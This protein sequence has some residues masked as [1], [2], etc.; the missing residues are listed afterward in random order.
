MRQKFSL[1]TG[2][3]VFGFALLAGA[4]GL[5]R[6]GHTT[7]TPRHTSPDDKG[8]YA[9]LIDTNGGYAYFFGSY[10][11]KLDITGNLPVQIGPALSSGQY[12][13]G[14]ID[15]AAGYAYMP[16]AGTIYRYA[17]GAGTNAV[18]A[19]GSLI[20]PEGASPSMSIVVDDSDPNPANHY[21]YVLCSGTPAKV[22]K[23]ALGTFTEVSSVT[24]NAGENAF[25]WGRIDVQKGYAYFAS[26]ATSVGPVIPQVVKIKLTPGTNAPIRLG[27]VNLGGTPVPLWTSSIDTL[28]GY[29]YYGTDNGTT[30]IPETV[31]KVKLG[32]G[33]ALP[34]PVPFGG[35]SLRTNEIQLI[36]QV[37]DPV[38]GYLYFGAD[39]T[40]PGRIYQFS[41][42]GTNPPVEIGYLQLQG[43]T[44]SSTPINGV[45]AGNIAGDGSNL[46]YGE[47]FFRS[48]VIDP[49]SG[50]AYFGQDSRPNQVV[51]VALAQNLPTKISSGT[52]LI[53]GAFQLAFTNAPYAS[54]TALTST[55]PAEPLSNWTVLGSVTEIAPGQYQFTDTPP[56]NTPGRFYRIRSP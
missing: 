53:G 55:N 29:A 12:S 52:K 35:V 36:S 26:W 10:L 48:A 39:N 4:D 43:G 30:N 51:K 7:L 11:F 38:R 2:A 50:F 16:R 45:T 21:A 32:D 19:A 44:N 1:L 34:S 42:N 33:D 8:M 54:F 49:A 20:L 23:V 37:V 41:L 47:V 3:L 18:A 22:V 28:H 24:L 31:F 13:E 14:A 17:L 25:A 40:Y 56:A 5:Q 27:I 46:P 15:P 9:A 6:I